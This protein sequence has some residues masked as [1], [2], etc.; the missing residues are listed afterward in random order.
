MDNRYFVCL[1][2]EV[3]PG[4]SKSFILK[5]K[6]QNDLEIALFNVEGKFYAISEKCQHNQGPL[7]KGTIDDGNIV[8]CP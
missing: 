1:T 5:V 6:G 2:D 3:G 8:T 7:S 4:K